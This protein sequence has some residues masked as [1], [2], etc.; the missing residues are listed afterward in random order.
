MPCTFREKFSTSYTPCLPFKAAYSRT[1]LVA[2]QHHCLS[3]TYFPSYPNTHHHVF[4]PHD[5]SRDLPLYWR[6][7][8]R[9]LAKLGVL[10][11]W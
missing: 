9:W 10:S 6:S 4:K 11:E 7:P 8:W 1:V 5:S 2:Y 3:A